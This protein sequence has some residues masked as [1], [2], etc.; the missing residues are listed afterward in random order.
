MLVRRGRARRREVW[1][2]HAASGRVVVVVSFGSVETRLAEGSVPPAVDH[3]Q[4][5]EEDEKVAAVPVADRV[6]PRAA[7]RVVEAAAA[8]DAAELAPGRLELHRRAGALAD[9]QEPVR[10]PVKRPKP[11]LRDEAAEARRAGRARLVLQPPRP[12]TVLALGAAKVVQEARLVVADS[13]CGRLR[14]QVRERLAVERVRRALDHLVVVGTVL[15]PDAV[16]VERVTEVPA[17]VVAELL[18]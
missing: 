6:A 15:D 10:Q 1:A 8:A 2:R 9:L 16:N 14:A 18:A 12:G 13:R 17:R 7:V 4:P 11:R 5:R 3:A